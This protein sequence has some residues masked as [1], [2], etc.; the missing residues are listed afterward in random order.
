MLWVVSFLPGILLLLLSVA[1]LISFI[2]TLVTNPQ[3]FEQLMSRVVVLVLM[4]GLLWWMYM[5]LPGFVRRT[6]GRGWQRLMRKQ[7]KRE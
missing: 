2:Q 1:V 7:K 3:L 5:W 6:F 4:L